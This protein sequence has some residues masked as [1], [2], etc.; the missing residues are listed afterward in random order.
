M[1]IKEIEKLTGMTRANIRFYETEGL[2]IPS[3]SANGYRNYTEEDLRTLQR[4]RLLRTLHLSLEEIKELSRGQKYLTDALLSHLT[5]LK[6]N[7]TDLG[8]C[9]EICEKICRDHPDYRSLDAQYY[10]SLM[11][12]LSDSP[13]AEL[14]EDALPKVTSPW[15]RLMARLI[16]L[17]IYSLIWDA[18]LSLATHV[19]IRNGN[20]GSAF[21]SWLGQITLLL[22]LEPVMLSLT[23][24]TPGKFLFGLSVTDPEGARLTRKKAFR[25]T[26]IMLRYG[27][28]Y[29]IP[30]YNLFRMYRSYKGCKKEEILEWEADSFLNLKNRPAPLLAAGFAAAEAVF[31]G[32]FLLIWQIG[33]LPENQG[34]LTVAEFCENYNQTQ[35]FYG[36]DRP[37]NI[38]VSL[39]MYL[40]YH[41]TYSM[42]LDENGE[43]MHGAVWQSFGNTYGELPQLQFEKNGDMVTGI[44]FSM[45]Y[46][47]E[48]VRLVSYND[49]MAATAVSFICA[50]DNYSILST[51]PQT[52][53]DYITEQAGNYRDFTFSAA[54]V[55]IDCKMEFSGYRMVENGAMLVP[56]YG[57]EPFY[58]L[59]FSMQKTR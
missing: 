21:F 43:W 3:R 59:E 17:E 56:E 44:N 33:S 46:E 48:S 12:C 11:D 54:G 24:T 13:A 16:D 10:L 47:N 35:Q 18:F 36:I 55:T 19:N 9:R 26:W 50:Q 1:T 52:I 58:R 34:D 2:I 6:G 4:I 49:F 7:E 31:C 5:H 15:K 30:V 27:F 57:E 32:A 25:R 29:C 14:E 28:G 40:A 41:P 51:P 39:R 53:Y 20:M 45:T 23:G 42:L 22:L 8:R 38:P 37:V